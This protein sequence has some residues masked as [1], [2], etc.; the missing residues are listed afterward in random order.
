MTTNGTLLVFNP[1]TNTTK[2][3]DPSTIPGYVGDFKCNQPSGTCNTYTMGTTK[4][5]N[6]AYDY[7]TNDDVLKAT[8]SSDRTN[9]SSTVLT[10]LSS[11]GGRVLQAES[12]NTVALQNPVLCIKKG[13]IMFFNVVP[14]DGNYP[15]YNKDSILNTNPKFDYGPFLNLA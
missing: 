1:V 7:S 10:R 8:N 3:V 13:D 2:S 14:E 6:F 11:T 5:G 12:S 15:V 9:M 4:D